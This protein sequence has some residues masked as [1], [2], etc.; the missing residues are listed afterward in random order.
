[1]PIMRQREFDLPEHPIVQNLERFGCPF[2]KE[3][4]IP[5]CPIC[6]AECETIYRNFL[7][8]VVG[9]DLCVLALDAEDDSDLFGI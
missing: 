6:G 8:E 4:P 2:G 3:P 7:N 9:F 1:M 5:H